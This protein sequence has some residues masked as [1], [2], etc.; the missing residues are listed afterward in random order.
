MKRIFIILLLVIV[1]ILLA[2]FIEHKGG[3][4][5]FGN[6]VNFAPAK[7]SG[8]IA[9]DTNK[10]PATPEGDLIKYGKSLIVNT[11]YYFGPEGIIS[12]SGNGMNCQNCHLNAGTK[13]FGINFSLVA[14]SYPRY[15]DRSSSMESIEKKVED[16]FERSMNGQTIDSNSREM[17]AFVSYL[18]WVGSNVAIGEKP[19]GAGVEELALMHRAADASKGEI[20]YVNKC[21]VCHGKSGQGQSLP[22]SA[23]NMYPPLWGPNSYN[24]GASIYRISKL[25]G[26]VKNN[27][28]L[29]A[30]HQSPQLTDEEAWDVAAFVNTKYHPPKDLSGDWLI[31]IKKP[32]DYPFG[33]FADNQFPASQHKYGPYEPI[34][35]YYAKV[36]NK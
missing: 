30:T 20:V 32:Y 34:K 17:K 35:N 16:C 18:K 27:M 6:E 7:S 3:R 10:I 9:P 19:I 4:K 2:I 13:L 36:E 28:P 25:A 31:I 33:P 5:K 29:G 23:G 12:H 22:D 8:W 14:G 21:Q 1:I 11:A 24:I 15:K 26:F